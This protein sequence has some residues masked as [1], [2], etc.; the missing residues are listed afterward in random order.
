MPLSFNEL[1]KLIKEKKIFQ[2]NSKLDNALALLKRKDENAPALV[3]VSIKTECKS[4]EEVLLMILDETNTDEATVGYTLALWVASFLVNNN[5]S[6]ADKKEWA[7]ILKKMI[8]LGAAAKACDIE[9]SVSILDF[10]KKYGDDDLIQFIESA[11]SKQNRDN[12]NNAIP[13]SKGYTTKK[14]LPPS[15]SRNTSETTALLLNQ[16]SRQNINNQSSDEKVEESYCHPSC[17]IL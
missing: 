6:T 1:V 9:N 16:V 11:I 8:E 17:T 14:A 10:A 2:I 3:T 7:Q 5:T 4:N 15:T 13:Q 12:N